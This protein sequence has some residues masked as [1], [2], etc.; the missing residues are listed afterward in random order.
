MLHRLHEAQSRA[1]QAGDD[2]GAPSIGSE[3]HVARDSGSLQLLGHRFV[4][5]EHEQPLVLVRGR[6][7][8]QEPPVE[9]E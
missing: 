6:R 3:C 2:V 7:R 4:C 5:P 8:E 9:V 1:P